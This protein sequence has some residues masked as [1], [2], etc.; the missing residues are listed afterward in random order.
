MISGRVTEFVR[1]GDTVRRPAT[2][3]T[4]SMRQLL[5]HLERSGFEGAPRVV[6]SEPDGSVVLTWIDGWVP[7]EAPRLAEMVVEVIAGCHRSV[8]RK[9]AAGIPAFVRMQSEG[10]LDMLDGQCQAAERSRPL[11]QEAALAS[12]S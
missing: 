2:G 5:V 7:T 12:I 4:E 3:S 6:N 9:A 11:I 1:L 10:V 8:A